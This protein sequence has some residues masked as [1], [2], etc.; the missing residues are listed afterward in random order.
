MPET[1]AFRKLLGRPFWPLP[2]DS[3]KIARQCPPPNA[4]CTLQ[5]FESIAPIVT[6]CFSWL[7][8]ET[9]ARDPLAGANHLQSCSF[10]LEHQS[11]CSIKYALSY[12]IIKYSQRFK[13][14]GPTM[15]QSTIDPFISLPFVPGTFGYVHLPPSCQIQRCQAITIQ[16]RH[17]SRSF[18]QCPA[19]AKPVGNGWKNRFLNMP[20]HEVNQ[21]DQPLSWMISPQLL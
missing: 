2:S 13:T 6:F 19:H 15:H 7:L 17:I 11:S 5:T 10:Q 12:I 1:K 14:N 9:I 20:N 16:L 3:P 4:L 8:V 18:Q 21:I